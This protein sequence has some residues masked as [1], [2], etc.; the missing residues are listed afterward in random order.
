MY[1]VIRFDIYNS[2]NIVVFRCFPWTMNE[3][4]KILI[5]GIR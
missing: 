4:I 5:Y 3:R 1:N 2:E